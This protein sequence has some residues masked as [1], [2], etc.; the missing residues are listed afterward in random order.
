MLIYVLRLLQLVQ[1]EFFLQEL[2]NTQLHQMMISFL[3]IILCLQFPA[4]IFCKVSTLFFIM[5]QSSAWGLY[6][7]Y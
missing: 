6:T 1:Y 5:S 3:V 2:Q 4:I 7:L